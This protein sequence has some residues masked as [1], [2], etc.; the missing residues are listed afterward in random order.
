MAWVG[1]DIQNP[2][3]GLKFSFPFGEWILLHG[4]PVKTRTSHIFLMYVHIPDADRFQCHHLYARHL[5]MTGIFHCQSHVFSSLGAHQ[6]NIVW[7]WCIKFMF[8]TSVKGLGFAKQAT[9]ELLEQ[10]Y[11][12]TCLKDQASEATPLDTKM[13]SFKTGG[14]WSQ[15]QLY[16]NVG[17][18]AQ[19]AW[20]FKRGGLSWQWSVKIAFIVQVYRTIPYCWCLVCLLHRG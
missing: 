2:A 20:S 18:S 7:A 19:N 12:R 8:L 16:W 3:A 15:V 4:T 5:F 1:H 17:P 13:W 10:Y 6:C 14:L 11:S 9:R